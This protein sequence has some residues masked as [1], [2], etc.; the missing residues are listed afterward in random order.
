MLVL[1][2][3]LYAVHWLLYNAIE[4][5][6][7]GTHRTI[8]DY[9]YHA[10][11]EL[12]P[13]TG[14]VAESWLG[15]YR[16]IVVGLI[17]SAVTVVL[18]QIIFVILQLDWTPV[19]GLILSVVVL[20]L[21]MLGFG[22]LYTNMLPFTLDQMIGASAEELSA[23]VQWYYWGFIIGKLIRDILHCISIPR[24]LEFVDV[25]PVVLL[26]LGSLC[27][28]AVMIMA[29]LYHKWLD[30]NDKTGNPIKFIFEVLNYA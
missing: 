18:S 14:C 9:T 20:A 7:K 24:Q 12:L 28:S 1:S 29:C 15:R 11:F 17:L 25:I 27:L 21:G 2:G 16:A 8:L 30:T 23:V 5:S 4:F 10:I 6:V 19:P 26:M 13:L 22:S 3:L